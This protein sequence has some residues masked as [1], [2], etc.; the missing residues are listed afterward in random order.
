MSTEG[1]KPA[2]GLDARRPE[3]VLLV[4]GGVRFVDKSV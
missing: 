2:A 4:V 3:D 1:D